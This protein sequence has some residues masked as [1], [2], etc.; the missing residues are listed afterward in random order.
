MGKNLIKKKKNIFI[1]KCSRLS[2]SPP[3]LLNTHYRKK[4]ILIFLYYRKKK[5]KL[6]IYIMKIFYIYNLLYITL[7]KNTFVIMKIVNI[8]E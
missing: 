4:K 6:Y 2:Q 3:Y 5:K 7:F 1:N 8:Y